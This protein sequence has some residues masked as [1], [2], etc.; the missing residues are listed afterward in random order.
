MIFIRNPWQT[1]ICHGSV[2]RRNNGFSLVEL[3][4]V[5][6]ILSFLAFF[7]IPLFKAPGYLQTEFSKSSTGFA[8]F[9][10]GLRQKA[11][12]EHMDYELHIDMTSGDA[13]V[14]MPGGT[15]TDSP[16]PSFSGLQISGIELG[17]SDLDEPENAIIRFSHTGITD[18]AVIRME[19]DD[20]TVTLRLHPFIETVE[21]IN[22]AYSL[23]D[24]P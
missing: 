11:V 4:V 15:D 17:P 6:F 16:K 13:W 24:C 12:K 9:M 19:E 1:G 8:R 5:M 21:I 18:M 3:I 7:T 2:V 20:D 23:N 10:D 14:R 22:G